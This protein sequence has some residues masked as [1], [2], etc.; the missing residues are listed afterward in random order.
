MESIIDAAAHVFAELG[1]TSTTTNH[2]AAAAGV[3]IGSLYQYFPNKDALLVALERRHLHEARHI[4]RRAAHEWRQE[5]PE[6]DEWASSF[7]DAL[8]KVNDTPLHLLV[9]DT[10]P[11]LPDLQRAAEQIVADLAKDARWHLHRWGHRR[12]IQL[13]SQVL[14]VSAIR[15]VHDVAIR[16]PP[17]RRRERVRDEIVRSV[18][19]AARLT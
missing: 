5:R 12:G 7:V 10:A 8:I 11:P 2:V 17:G 3:S 13:R 15:L 18:A 1:Y 14:V 19:A 4:L 6:V 9:Y 16:T